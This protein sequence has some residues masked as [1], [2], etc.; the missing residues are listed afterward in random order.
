MSKKV[1]PQRNKRD[2]TRIGDRIA[3]N[4]AR[5]NGMHP[6]REDGHIASFLG[7]IHGWI[8]NTRMWTITWSRCVQ[9]TDTIGPIFN[10]SST[11][12]HLLIRGVL[13][14]E[15]GVHV[16][17]WYPRFTDERKELKVALGSK[18]EPESLVELML[19]MSY[20]VTP[21]RGAGAPKAKE[22]NNNGSL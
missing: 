7:L 6:R 10:D 19:K 3:S 22:T 5:R 2:A 18:P 13:K 16:H 20:E 4:D 17:F 11:T 9:I 21:R 1:V 14:L 8:A 12:R 15:D